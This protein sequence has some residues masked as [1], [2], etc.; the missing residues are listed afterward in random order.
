MTRDEIRIK[1][2]EE[3]LREYDRRKAEGDDE[4]VIL[5]GLIAYATDSAILG[6]LLGGSVTGSI[7]GDLLNDDDGDG[8]FD[9]LFD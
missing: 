2:G 3:G 6:T 1:Y 4:D 8:F 9:D 5:S 7:V